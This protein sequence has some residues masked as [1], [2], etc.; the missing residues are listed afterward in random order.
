VGKSLPFYFSYN[1]CLRVSERF[2]AKF[3]ESE[4]FARIVER[5]S[6]TRPS[7]SLISLKKDDAYLIFS[8]LH[9]HG[10]RLPQTKNPLQICSQKTL[11]SL[12]KYFGRKSRVERKKFREKEG[13]ARKL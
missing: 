12:F 3:T 6:S 4:N 13:Q 9:C 2:Q 11:N 8:I 1:G 7:R 10:T 5:Q